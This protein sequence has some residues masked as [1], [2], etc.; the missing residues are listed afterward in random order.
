MVILRPLDAIFK[1][2]NARAS[3]KARKDFSKVIGDLGLKVVDK[4]DVTLNL[5]TGKY[6]PGNPTTIYCTSTANPII[7][8]L[9]LGKFQQP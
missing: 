8:L 1:N 3:D 5:T 4:L 7:L 9:Q 2:M 6:Y